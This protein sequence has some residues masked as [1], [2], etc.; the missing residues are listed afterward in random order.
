MTQ[1]AP[2]PLRVLYV[3]S[4]FPCWS[5]TFILR[6][7]RAL[8][9]LGVDVRI[10]SLKAPSETLVQAEAA[11][12]RDRVWHPLPRARALQACAR[13]TLRHP[14]TLLRAGLR[15]LSGLWRQPLALAKSLL[16][17][18]R[19]VQQIDRLRAFDPHWIHAHWATYP[20]TAAWLL[21][22]LS[23]RPFGFTCHAHDLFSDRQLLAGKIKHARLAV[24]ISR[25]N[26]DWIGQHIGPS[27]AQRMRLVRCGVD[28][29]ALP[30]RDTGREPDLL[31]AVGRLDPIKG[32]DV[33]ILALAELA[34][35]GQQ[36]RCC[37]VGEG[38][39]RGELE[40]AI[41]QH[42]LRNRVELVGALP[43]A[44]VRERL[45]RARLFVLPC[46]IAADGN[47][48]GIP[49]A[50]MEAMAAGTPVLSTTVSGVPELIESAREGLLVPADDVAA[51][52]AAIADLLGDDA[53]C[54]RLARAARA[55]VERQ[56]DARQE[57]ATLLSLVQEALQ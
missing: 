31:L 56:F 25:Y 10:L 49:V 51:L 23:Q 32:F 27:A 37:I 13:T 24:T 38:P 41:A 45:Y 30:L 53:L 57:A 14:R 44:E 7:I 18:A 40:Q 48:D 4:L 55:K 26:I 19:G 39:Q 20:S 42:A 21:A 2:A 28:L 50:L 16:A 47:R 3:V 33:L 36:F 29:A 8:I 12:V 52:S 5:E 11:A 22:D 1:P 15:V 6:E 9:D 54:Q 43:Q 46:R 17:L 35:R 34:R